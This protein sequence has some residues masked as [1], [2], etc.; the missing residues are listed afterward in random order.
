MENKYYAPSIK[1][2]HVGFEFEY[3]AIPND[4]E[5]NDG[6]VKSVVDSTWTLAAIEHRI[7]DYPILRIKYLDKE[8]IESFGF[9]LQKESDGVSIFIKEFFTASEGYWP[10]VPV[11]QRYQLELFKDNE[12]VITG[13]GWDDLIEG[14]DKVIRWVFF[15]GK[16]KNK[17]E[18]KR[19]LTQI[20]VIE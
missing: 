5:S 19:L 4:L 11:E 17:S 18:F 15:R 6:F 3:K 20:G 13:F 10:V 2:F 8:D 7:V 16:I 14:E 9:I 12:I 1:E